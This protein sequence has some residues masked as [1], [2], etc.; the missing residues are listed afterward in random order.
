MTGFNRFRTDVD[1]R[2]C[3]LELT[4]AGRQFKSTLQAN[5]C[6]WIVL[7]F[8]HCLSIPDDLA[9]PAAL[10][11]NKLLPQ[12]GY[13]PAQCHTCRHALVRRM[14]CHPTPNLRCLAANTRCSDRRCHR[15][16]C[17][18]Q[19]QGR[20]TALV[21]PLLSSMQSSYAI[22]GYNLRARRCLAL[23]S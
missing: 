12:A 9:C 10:P 21:V 2:L 5:A 20:G 13:A 7:A 6:G 3:E 15:I 8:E 17:V 4:G 11:L 23:E 22:K 18:R 14:T 1:N 19:Q 16:V